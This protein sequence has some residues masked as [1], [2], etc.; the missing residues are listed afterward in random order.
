M[1]YGT[2]HDE[3]NSFGSGLGYIGPN[4]N[5]GKGAFGHPE[6]ATLDIPLSCGIDS[7][8]N[9][10]ISFN[11]QYFSTIEAVRSFLT[12]WSNSGAAPFDTSNPGAVA[13]YNM[14]QSAVQKGGQIEN[15]KTQGVF[16]ADGTMAGAV[17]ALK[18]L[19]VPFAAY[20]SP[21]APIIAPAQPSGPPLTLAPGTSLSSVT[22]L[23]GPGIDKMFNYGASAPS[24]TRENTSGLSLIV[25]GVSSPIDSLQAFFDSNSKW[26]MKVISNGTAYYFWDVGRWVLKNP[27]EISPETWYAV[28]NVSN[29]VIPPPGYEVLSVGMGFVYPLYSQAPNFNSDGTTT[30]GGPGFYG[31][32]TPTATNI[33]GQFIGLDKTKLSAGLYACKFTDLGPIIS[34]AGRRYQLTMITFLDLTTGKI[35]GPFFQTT[36]GGGGGLLISNPI[37]L[38]SRIIV[39]VATWGNAEAA[40]AGAKSAGVSQKNIDLVTEGGAA[41]AIALATAGVAAGISASA[42]SATASAAFP[43]A[44]DAGS[45]TASL[46]LPTTAQVAAMNAAGAT[47]LPASLSLIAPAAASLT[48]AEAVTGVAAT[49]AA[50]ETAAATL[51]ASS[52]AVPAAIKTTA[53]GI[54]KALQAAV[55]ST[56]VTA[57]STEIKKLTGQLPGAKPPTQMILSPTEISAPSGSSAT[58]QILTWGLGALAALAI[59]KKHSS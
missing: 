51:P 55:V 58:K 15:V 47:L 33:T 12:I 32:T 4:P 2:A 37:A 40:R 9:P 41:L 18:F 7:S 52:V 27:S 19:G 10:W 11:N 53:A 34:P 13:G 14:L 16:I 26:G 21:A 36:E 17:G 23:V 54:T 46:I 22:A 20:Q 24:L 8:G 31:L 5:Y 38:A 59:F 28:F 6:P 29:T 45:A 49:A 56:G 48:V 3:L 1:I 25:G 57:L 43:V 30:I 44:A 39:D 50:P 42:T 35:I